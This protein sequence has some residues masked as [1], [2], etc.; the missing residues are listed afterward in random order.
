[1]NPAGGARHPGRERA[2]GVRAG[3]R[4]SD[5]RR[6]R[7]AGV[8]RA[9]GRR[10]RRAGR[11]RAR[12]ALPAGAPLRSGRALRGGAGGADA[13]SLGGQ[14]RSRA[15]GA[16]SWRA[17]LAR[18][19]SRSRSSPRRRGRPTT[20]WATRRPSDSR[21]ARRSA[22]RAI[23]SGAVADFRRAI[24]AVGSG[25]TAVD[26]ALALV[27]HRRERHGRQ[28]RR[29]S[30]TRWASW[31]R[32][33]PRTRRWRRPRRARRRCCARPPGQPVRRRGPR[34][35]V[36]VGQ[37]RVAAA[38]A[39]G[40]GGAQAAV[41]GSARRARGGRRGAD[42]DGVP[43]RA[44]L[45]GVVRRHDPPWK[46]DLLA[47]AAARARLAGMD[48]ADAVARRA[49][50]TARAPALAPAISDLPLAAGGAWP[51]G[52]PDTRRA[53]ARRNGGPFGT[54]LDLEVAL[55]A[56]RR[57]AL[58]S[59]LAIYGS[60]IAS[61][62]ERL[63]A[64]SG[65]R[66]VARAGGD[67]IGEARA[68]ARLG[69]VVRDPGE[70]AALLAEAAAVYERAGR[71]DDAITALAKC[72]ELRPNDSTAYMRA[73]KLLRADLEA[74]GRSILFDALLSHR[75][76]AATLTPAARVALLFERGQH[77]LQRVADREAAFADF[78]EILK[79]QPE[80]REALFQLARGASED[81]RRRIG[82][83][84]AGAVP[85]RRR[86][87]IRA[88]R[89]PAWTWR[90]ATRRSRTG[91]APWRRCGAPAA[92][93]PAIPKP[94]AAPRRPAPAPGRVE[95]RRS[96]PCARPRR[97]CADVGERAASAPAHRFDP[98]RSG[99]RRAGRG[100]RPSGARPS[101]IRWARARARSSRSTIRRAIRGA[102][103]SPS[104]TRS[105]MSGARWPRIR[106]TCGA[107]SAC[108]SCSRWRA[109]AVPPRRSTK[110]RPWSRA[111]SIW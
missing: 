86:P 25:P 41:G 50:E 88:R 53:R 106:W 47:R 99:P 65:I 94:L 110:P 96:R 2:G 69:A 85:R 79:I 14:I 15:P 52:R 58:G 39:R 34:G 51:D 44:G 59:A 91:R 61:D 101:W 33:A 26:A 107:W 92:C 19:S 67:T 17:G 66:R 72:V 109:P 111:C 6:A 20:C 105:R 97:G 64:W 76:A 56:E 78:K 80:H 60:I 3:G 23:P 45:R 4:P 35:D 71:V 24:A 84:L 10:D 90:P 42:R 28:G 32:R 21:T 87:T 31:R 54:A 8:E 70:A 40:H 11:G 29:R 30:R 83:A 49:W 1:M 48:A 9:R 93:A 5:G 37:R 7:R 36:H 77:R 95:A 18:R 22:A 75:L 27:A 12:A 73:Y 57:G 98:A 43:G 74:P 62:P 81:G 102:R 55:D 63:E 108:A 16:T 82:G 104:I 46:A 38:R 89:T 68:L 103:W 100:G 13:A